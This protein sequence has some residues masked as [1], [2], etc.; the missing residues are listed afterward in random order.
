MEAMA[1]SLKTRE[2]IL[3]LCTICHLLTSMYW[4]L[5]SRLNSFLW[6][7]YAYIHKP[8]NTTVSTRG[9]RITSESLPWPHM[10]FT[11]GNTAF[12]FLVNKTTKH[13]QNLICNLLAAWE[14][15]LVAVTLNIS[16]R[17]IHGLHISNVNKM[18]SAPNI[19]FPTFQEQ[20][21]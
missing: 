17:R 1:I 18:K 11:V 12:I 15:C 5:L 8:A 6:R 4:N 9:S 3:Y 20:I 16:H 19:L 21:C 7:Q 14:V 2:F 13:L 10:E